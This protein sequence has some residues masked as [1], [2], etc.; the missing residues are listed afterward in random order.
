MKQKEIDDLLNQ[1]IENV[2][3]EEKQDLIE[4]LKKVKN[5]KIRQN[6]A[7]ILIPSIIV[8]GGMGIFFDKQCDAFSDTYQSQ[9]YG[10]FYQTEN[11]NFLKEDDIV[12]SN[13][14]D[15][16]EYILEKSP[17]EKSEDSDYYYRTLKYYH[18]DIKMNQDTALEIIDAGY[19]NISDY[20][21]S[22]FKSEKEITTDQN[23]ID[24]TKD[25][26]V[27]VSYLEMTKNETKQNTSFR[28]NGFLFL[29]FLFFALS[30]SMESIICFN[31]N[32]LRKLD[33]K[34]ESLGYKKEKKK[35]FKKRK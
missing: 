17:W 21:R 20:E 27:E 7:I 1:S 31:D 33:Y 4:G 5:I 13:N 9:Y 16:Y 23:Y 14:K 28:K 3:D 12:L 22:V 25:G 30:A 19:N 35:L 2:N 24:Q 8:S 29:C 6:I 10:N 26:E 18:Y 34:L 32:T 11:N 15:E